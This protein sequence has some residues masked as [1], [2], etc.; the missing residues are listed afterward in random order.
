MKM[1]F[2]NG[3]LL[4]TLIL[5]FLACSKQKEL[6]PAF[7]IPMSGS[8]CGTWMEP[9]KVDDF[10][11]AR[12][13]TSY[14]LD[15]FN[16]DNQTTIKNELLAHR[17]VIV[18][19]ANCSVC[20]AN[21]HIWVIDGVKDLHGILQDPNGNCYEYSNYYYQMNWGWQDTSQNDTWFAYNNIVGG[22]TL[23]NSSNMKAYI[24]IPN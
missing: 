12:G 5:S 19:G 7:G 1:N 6:V 8:G 21:T 10:F 2:K 3:A 14:D 23:Y 9:G 11:A 20:L 15:F 16:A 24:I 4:F 13:F 22:G 17:P 18:F